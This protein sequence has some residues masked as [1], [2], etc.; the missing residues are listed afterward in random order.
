MMNHSYNICDRKWY[1]GPNTSQ[2]FLQKNQKENW[3]QPGVRSP[4]RKKL[5]HRIICS[6]THTHTLT[7]LLDIP[8]RGAE[9]VSGC[10]AAPGVRACC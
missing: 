6:H 2:P 3:W 1:S 10:R 5:L 9:E 4:V 8:I 7:D